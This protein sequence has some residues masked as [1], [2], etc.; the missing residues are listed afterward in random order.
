[1]KYIGLPRP[2]YPL[3]ASIKHVISVPAIVKVREKENDMI[4]FTEQNCDL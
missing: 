4:D 1:M 2:S 3:A